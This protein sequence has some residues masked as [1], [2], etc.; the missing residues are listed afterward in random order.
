MMDLRMFTLCLC[1][2]YDKRNS[3]EEFPIGRVLRQM[4]P[5]SPFLFLFV[6]NGLNI[7]MIK[8]S[9]NGPL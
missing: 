6:V 7:M 2:S 5:L 3:S 8:G 9:R 1:A 4:D